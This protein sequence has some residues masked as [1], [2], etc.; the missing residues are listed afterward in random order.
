ML[1]SEQTT[2]SNGISKHSGRLMVVASSVYK[3]D[4][5]HDAVCEDVGR[6]AALFC[7]VHR[8][9]GEFGLDGLGACNLETNDHV[10]KDD[11]GYSLRQ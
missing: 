2:K 10:R 1:R 4:T 7:M 5:K 3:A 8:L 6:L 9:P 11:R